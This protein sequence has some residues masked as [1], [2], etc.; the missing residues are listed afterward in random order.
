MSIKIING[1]LVIKTWVNLKSY[2]GNENYKDKGFYSFVFCRFVYYVVGL[3]SSFDALMAELLQ[4]LSLAN[5]LCKV[6]FCKSFKEIFENVELGFFLFHETESFLL[7][8]YELFC[9]SLLFSFLFLLFKMSFKDFF[10]FNPLLW[11]FSL[12]VNA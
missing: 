7:S 2:L 12:S 3:K 9:D 4:F 5:K 10:K 8:F 6:T 11:L 1:N